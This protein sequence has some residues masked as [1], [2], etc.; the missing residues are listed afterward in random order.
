MMLGMCPLGG[1]DLQMTSRNLGQK[2]TD[3]VEGILFRNVEKAIPMK[4]IL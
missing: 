2:V 4:F 1:D 3:V